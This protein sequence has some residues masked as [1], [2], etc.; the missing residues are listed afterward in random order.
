MYKDLSL[1][2]RSPMFSVFCFVFKRFCLTLSMYMSA[3]VM[4][5]SCL[6]VF[7]ACGY[8]CLCDCI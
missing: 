1:L 8:L 3:L 6:H 5:S 7:R 2:S 4:L